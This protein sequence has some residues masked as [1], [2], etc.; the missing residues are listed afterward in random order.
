MNPAGGAGEPLTY[1]DTAGAGKTFTHPVDPGRL[2]TVDR[3]ARV[4]D[5]GCGYGRVMAE[6]NRLGFSDPREGPGDHAG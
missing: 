5:Y 4:L 6:P 1:W 3:G 2:A